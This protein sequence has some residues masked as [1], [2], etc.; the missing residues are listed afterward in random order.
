MSARACLVERVVESPWIIRLRTKSFCTGVLKP[1]YGLFR[2]S[3]IQKPTIFQVS[4][5]SNQKVETGF[6]VYQ[7]PFEGTGNMPHKAQKPMDTVNVDGL[8]ICFLVG[9]LTIMI[10]EM[11]ETAVR[12]Y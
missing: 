10:R 5:Y 12:Q 8:G 9:V 11:A 6:G 7:Y 1:K 4:P 3:R 2:V